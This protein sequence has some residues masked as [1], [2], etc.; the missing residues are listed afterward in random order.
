MT[1]FVV[2]SIIGIHIKSQIK[3]TQLNSTQTNHSKSIQINSNPNQPNTHYSTQLNSTQLNSNSNSNY[4]S[5][6]PISFIVCSK[7][8]PSQTK[9]LKKEKKNKTKQKNTRIHY[10]NH[11]VSNY[12]HN[13]KCVY[14]K[15][16]LI[17]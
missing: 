8:H 7:F 15:F 10:T 6:Q 4:N 3:S 5:T 11:T 1:T 12:H 2:R 14:S 13:L 9:K 16:Q 17:L